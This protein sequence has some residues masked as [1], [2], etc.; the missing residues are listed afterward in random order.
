MQK[1]LEKTALFYSLT[2]A[3]ID[4]VVSSAGGILRRYEAG[5]VLWH[6]GDR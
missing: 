2:G 4:A 5:E 3:E 1:I 6:Q